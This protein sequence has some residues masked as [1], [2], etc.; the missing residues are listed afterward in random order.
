MNTR[1]GSWKSIVVTTGLLVFSFSACAA[2]PAWTAVQLPFHAMSIVAVEDTF[3]I[4]GTGES[5]AQSKDGGKTWEV[6]HSASPGNVLLDIGFIDAKRGYAAGTNGLL[7][8]TGD[9]GETWTQ[10]PAGSDSILQ[11]AFGDE[12]TGLIHTRSA[13]EFTRDAGAHWQEVAAFHTNPDMKGLQYVLN[14]TVLDPL[15]A[16]IMVKDGPAQY[17]GGQFLTSVDGGKNW[18]LINVPDMTLYS[19]IASHGKFWAFGTE[20]IEK[21]NHGGH[22]VPVE[23]NSSNG[24]DWVKADRPLNPPMDCNPRGCLLSDSVLFDPFGD[25]PAYWAFPGGKVVTPKWASVEGTICSIGGTTQCADAVHRDSVASDLHE[26]PPAALAQPPLNAP[27]SGE[28]Q[29]LVCASESILVDPKFGGRASVDV[30]LT[31][32][33]DGTIRE[34]HL[35]GAPTKEIEA[36][37]TQEI[38]AWVFEPIRRDG[39]PVSARTHLKLNINVIRSG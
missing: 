39:S 1:L 32:G 17:Y 26:S 38:M 6:K 23:L 12:Q 20:V 35:Q 7:L 11:A 25:K 5:I 8:W 18:K 27:K 14:M 29:C 16:V 28:L 24:Q 22:A 19:L 15:K 3:W 9:G 31:I 13:V 37:L 33:D 34:A 10:L 30:E 2:S 21:Q 36:K 4:C